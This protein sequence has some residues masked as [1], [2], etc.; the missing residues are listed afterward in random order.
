MA[1]VDYQAAQEAAKNSNSGGEFG[2][3]KLAN[4]ETRQ[5]R[6][7]FD[8]PEELD[9]FQYHTVDVVVNGVSKKRNIDC[10]RAINEPVQKCAFCASNYPVRNRVYIWLHDLTTNQLTLWEQPASVIDILIGHMKRTVSKFSHTVFEIERKGVAL[11]TKYNIY[12]NPSVVLTDAQ[13]IEFDKIQIEGRLVLN[14]TNEE[15]T[16]YIN[17]GA[18]PVKQESNVANNNY[19]SNDYAPRAPQQEEVQQASQQQPV[20]STW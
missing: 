10:N 9:C 18:F 13:L 1:R 11:Q 20:K 7:L 4:N 6:F 17:T 8:T 2:F 3:L 19:T 14:K 5:V 15:M 16:S 12:A